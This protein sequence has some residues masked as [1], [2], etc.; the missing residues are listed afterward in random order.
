MKSILVIDSDP[1]TASLTAKFLRN[2][3]YEVTV[4][5]DGKAAIDRMNHPDFD[6]VLC[7][8]RL[9][10]MNGFDVLKLMRRC[11]IETPFVFFASEDDAVT[12][13][14]AQSVGALRF[15]SKRKEYINLPH[16]LDQIFYPVFESRF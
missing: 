10:G 12:M 14:Q 15:I 4:V 16:I 13:L 9:Q 11:Y 6:L 5:S 2:Y 7:D 8:T 3:A 1:V